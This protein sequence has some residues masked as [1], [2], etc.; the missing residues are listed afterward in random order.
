M[1]RNNIVAAGLALVAIVAVG[2]WFLFRQPATADGQAMVLPTDPQSLVVETASGEHSFSIEVADDPGERQMG[3]M[4][5]QDMADDHG[6][7]FV[8]EA[9]GPV[10][11]W[12]KNTPMALDLI[13]VGQDGKVRAVRHGDPQSV[14]SLSPG[15]P[16]RFVFEVKAG[17]AGKLGIG[18]GDRMRHPQVERV[19]GPGAGNDAG[20]PG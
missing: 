5:R 8:F 19:T 16:V 20:N 7:L 9:T 2:S 1:I 11:F 4:Y 14:A 17:I 13:F 3:L 10:A 18:E 6:M 15:V 12:M